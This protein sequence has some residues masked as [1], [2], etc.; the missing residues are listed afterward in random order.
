MRITNGMMASQFLYD[1]NKS[2]NRLAKA[3]GT[4][5]STKKISNIAD[6][7]IATVN[8]LKARNKLSS[9]ANYQSN[10]STADEYLSESSDALDSINTLVSSAQALVDSANSGS[11]TDSDLNAIAE[12]MA[13]L[14]DEVLAV[15]NSSLGSVYLFSGN[16]SSKPFSINAAGHLIYNEID[17]TQ[18][19]DAEDLS[20]AQ[21]AI[22]LDKSDIAE[23][24]GTNA[25]ATGYYN[26][27]VSDYYAKNTITAGVISDLGDMLDSANS[28]LSAATDFGDINTSGLSSFVSQL[29]AIKTNLENESNKTVDLDGITTSL[30][31]MSD[32]FS[33]A[34]TVLK[35]NTTSSGTYAF[36]AEKNGSGVTVTATG[37]NGVTYTAN[38]DSS[39]LSAAGSIA[40][41][42]SGG[43]GTGFTT[44]L[45]IDGSCTGDEF[46]SGVDGANVTFSDHFNINNVKA[47]ITALNAQTAT[48][49][50][51]NT[52]TSVYADAASGLA[53]G[54]YALTATAN[55]DGT[56]TVESGG[57][58]A[59]ISTDTLEASEITQSLS[60]ALT[61]GGGNTMITVSLGLTG[62]T[63]DTAGI[64]ALADDIGSVS[65]AG[66]SV[67]KSGNTVTAAAQGTL[68]N[69]ASEMTA[70][71][72]KDIAALATETDAAQTIQIGRTQTVSLGVNGIELLGSGNENIYTLLDK[73][74]NMLRSGDTSGLSKAVSS[75]QDAQSRALAANTKVGASQQRMSI[76]SERY[77]ASNITYT[78]MQSDAEDADM[79]EAITDF[80]TAQ[81]VY[82]AALAGGAA[83]LQTSLVDFLS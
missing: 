35:S 75:L 61:D 10:V 44:T 23:L 73:C 72:A 42:F 55:G 20:D 65:T 58:S 60:A 26:P 12:E 69:I 17:M 82:S 76:I 24:A 50:K 14:R 43:D 52:V 27:D 6:D 38:V 45:S 66:I 31:K 68:T 37:D 15:S 5:D 62:F 11:K 67:T 71:T 48:N 1:A 19:S 77:S 40:L 29:K 41:D 22:A 57:Y 9:L 30:N 70:A 36:S 39:A 46:V 56:I 2:L 4:V 49:L 32:L 3:Q 80:K 54:T 21:S 8:A 83:I 81:T 78:G 13:S 34:S 63:N 18:L 33:S 25:S 7:P 64:A 74:V 51:E 47:Q 79:A 59:T 53:D 28:A 16:S